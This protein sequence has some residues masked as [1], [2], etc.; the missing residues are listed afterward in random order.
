MPRNENWH[1]A[2]SP[3]TPIHAHLAKLSQ[4]YMPMSSKVSNR[5]EESNVDERDDVSAP[6]RGFRGHEDL[7]QPLHQSFF[8][9]ITAAGSRRDI[10]SGSDDSA[11]SDVD[12]IGTSKHKDNRSSQDKRD[13]RRERQYL[14]SRFMRDLSPLHQSQSKAKRDRSQKETHAEQD[15]SRDD[16][17]AAS[18]RTDDSL[19]E[20]ISSVHLHHHTRQVDGAEADDEGRRDD[21]RDAS[22]EEEKH[23]AE[24][25]QRLKDTFGLSNPETI[26]SEN[27]AW[28]IRE[29]LL[30]GYM[31]ITEE[32]I[33]F[34]AYLPSQPMGSG[35]T[36]YLSKLRHNYIRY[37]RYW[38]SLRNDVLVYYSDPSDT[39]FPGGHI[40][41]RHGVSANQKN[42]DSRSKD[43]S[44]TTKNRTYYFRADSAN[45]AKSWVDSIREVIFRTSNK[46]DN[47]K[48]CIPIQNIVDMEESMMFHCAEAV[49]LRVIESDETYALDEYM[50]GFLAHNQDVTSMLKSLI[51]SRGFRRDGHDTLAESLDEG[52]G[53][54]RVPLQESVRGTIRSRSAAPRGRSRG[55]NLTS[56]TMRSEGGAPTL[57]PTVRPARAR[58]EGDARGLLRRP[59][60]VG[61]TFYNAQ[62]LLVDRS[63][64]SLTPPIIVQ[65]DTE[66]VSPALKASTTTY[67]STQPPPRSTDLHTD[68][69]SLLTDIDD[70]QHQTSIASKAASQG[71][72]KQQDAVVATSLSTGPG[73]LHELVKYGTYSLQRAA[74]LADNIKTRGKRVSSLLTSSPLGYYEKV[75]GMLNAP[76]RHYN[77]NED[78]V[79]SDEED[80]H[81]AQEHGNRFREHFGLSAAEKLMATHFA[82]LHRTLPLYGKIYIGNTT[83]CFRSLL[84]GTKTL[85][86]LPLKDIENIE[87]ERGFQ[88][89]YH[90]LAIIIRGHEE[91]FFQLRSEQSR[92]DCAVMLLRNIEALRNN[93]LPGSEYSEQ[94][95]A[96][97]GPRNTQVSMDSSATNL[98]ASHSSAGSNPVLFDDPRASIINFTPSEP[99]RITCL[100]IG[101]RGDVQ[102]Y[103]ALA[104]GLMAEGHILKIATHKEF[105]PWIRKHGIAF[106]PID[107]EPAELMRI[108]VENGMF[109]YSF[110]REASAKFRGWIDGL[111]SSSWAACQDCDLLIESPSAMGGI[112]IA[113]ALGIPYFR[114]FTMP[115]T[116]TR[117]YPHAFAVP[118]HKMGGAYNYMTYVMFDT[119]FWKAIA[120]QINAWRKKELKLPSTNLDKMQQTRVPFL[121]NFSPSVV[122]PPLDYSDWVR[123]T[124]YWF[125]NEATDWTPPDDLI[126][127]MEKAKKDGKKLVYI[128]FGSIVVADPFALTKTI[129][130][131]V[132][133]ADVRCILSK[134]WSGRLGHAPSAEELKFRMPEEIYEIGSVPHDWLFAR[135]DAVAHHGGAGTTGA[136]LRAGKPTLIKPFFGDQYF[137]GNRVEDLGVGIQMKKL[138]TSLLSRSLWEAT[139]NERMI[140]KARSLGEKIRSEDGVKT[141]IEALY[142]DLEYAQTL[143]WQKTQRKA[144][145][146]TTN[147]EESPLDDW[148]FVSHIAGKDPVMIS[149]PIQQ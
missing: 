105:E 117:V 51:D 108:C 86:V 42:G 106:A 130:D 75:S 70:A 96:E 110:L 78:I 124:G 123:V 127:F 57:K 116:R 134:G 60:A 142:R 61:P 135:M 44:V 87:Q 76:S 95:A 20:H 109:T 114:A 126:E 92:D 11:D 31:Y 100:T 88:F 39:Y 98:M 143:S 122:P 48:L 16:V 107:G 104:K 45:S 83:I 99:L 43:F 38:F 102:P 29:V 85:M 77:E 113:E 12:N 84:P 119:L 136:S 52:Q 32:H 101:S 21:Y 27:R 9:L 140:D 23:T 147:S 47:V 111:L 73:A 128:G 149:P 49:K 137:F 94:G 55:K 36:G 34:Y 112:H 125:L 63:G 72:Q 2:R 22:M 19:S 67:P 69:T 35:K 10:R 121:Y 145:A 132:L 53:L 71:Q 81:S 28:F 18:A 14:R 141:A 97:F 93:P 79:I 56:G 146:S 30:Q 64:Q 91:L 8:S 6:P 24:I 7:F 62:D 89:G 50:F 65:E 3:S 58:S 17:L 82:Y 5:D 40:D 74:E 138:N 15:K 115:W 144:N 46:G 133:K 90:G 59:G 37:T 118:E 120:W 68:Q 54:P 1:H 148:T 13:R 25:T 103:I 131:A 4:S 33:C 80:A 66:S 129:S 41:L 26:I 139:R